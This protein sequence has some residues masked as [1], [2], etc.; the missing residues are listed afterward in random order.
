MRMVDII[1][2]KR[3]GKVL[4]EEEIRFFVK[5]YT[6]GS[7]PDYQ[8]SA[9]AMAIVWR[10]MNKNEI[11]ILTDA[12]EHSGG[13][14]DLSSIKGVKV[15]KHSTGGVGDKTSL[16]LGPLVA[17]CGAKLAKMSG[18]GLGHTGGTLDKMESV[19]GMR[20]NLTDEEFV[21]QVNKIGIAII[22]QT[23][24]IDPADKKLYAL[25]DVTGTVESIP[26]IASSIMSKKLASGA[27]T[28]LLDVKFGSG[29]FM[30]TIED[31]KLLATTMV[32]IG[33][34]LHRDTRAII[35][36]MDEP[37]GLAVGNALE[38]KEAIATLHG[39][40]PRDFVELVTEAG[41][42]MLEQ[43]HI[44][45]DH[46]DGVKRIRAAI[47]DGS[48]FEKQKQFFAAQGG[49]ISYLEHPEKFPLATYIIPVLAEKAGYVKRIDSMAI[50][51]SAMKL[52]AGRATMTDKIDMAAGI[53]LNKKVGDH[54]AKGEVLAYAHTNMVGTEYTMK[55]IHNAFELSDQEVVVHPIVHA[56]IHK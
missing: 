15:D 44:A 2:K 20:I 45:K 16:A 47:A 51:V 33:D 19:P 11:A 21:N 55:D 34:S 35:T 27:D 23:A 7:V 43:A 49:D 13:T 48:G 52:G 38:V 40:G 14:I 46:E 56:Y 12:M 17:A 26:L 39:Q 42:I 8:A 54:V 41:A 30:K 1:E 37:L 10:G 50:G 53:V 6:D 32:E 3:D 36:D 25:R 5:G 28:I 24:E 9:L 31:A 22:G 29:A 4:T 18:R